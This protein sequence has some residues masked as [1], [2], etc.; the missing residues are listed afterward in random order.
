MPTRIESTVIIQRPV[1]EV[2]PFVLNLDASIQSMDSGVESIKKIPEGPVG[3][4]TTFRIR[5]HTL[6]R[7]RETTSRNTAIEPNRLIEFEAELGPVDATARMVFE[8]TD[9]ATRVTFSADPRPVGLFRLLAPLMMR[10]GQR[11][12]DRRLERL[13]ATLEADRA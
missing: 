6:G 8:P 1:A 3:V 7:L 12:W 11:A 5:Q 2:F 10:V 4:G 13:K 9:G